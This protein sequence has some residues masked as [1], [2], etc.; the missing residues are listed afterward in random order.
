M[1]ILR[2]TLPLSISALLATVAVAP[3]AT[4]LSTADDAGDSTVVVNEVESNGDSD[5]DWV[6]L[7]NTDPNHSTDVSGWS[8]VDNDSEHEP[9]VLPEGTEIESEGHLIVPTEPDFGLG[10]EDSVT[11]SDSDGAKVDETEWSGHAATTWGRVPDM[12]GD[13]AETGKPTKGLANAASDGSGNGDNNDGASAEFPHDPLEITDIEL[14]G[15]YV[16]DFAGE[17]MSGVDFAPDGTAYVVNNDAGTLYVLSPQGDNS[18][19]I[20]ARRTLHYQDGSGEP[21]T[22][23]VTVGQDGALYVATERDNSEGEDDTSR[24]SVLRYVL[25][26][27]ENKEH[28]DSDL[29]ATDEWNLSELA[30]E[31]GDISANGGLETIS[32]ISDAADPALFAVGVEDTGEVLF[33]SLSGDDARLVQRYESPFEGVMASDYDAD[34]GELMIMCDEA[35]DGASQVLGSGTPGDADFAPVAP[36]D[37]ADAAVNSRPSGMEN[38]ANEGYARFLDEDGTER[39]LWAD[40]GVTDGVSLRGAVSNDSDDKDDSDGDNASGSIPTGSTR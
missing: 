18:Y 26:D 27:E 38:F 1:R 20:D 15:D 37:T 33:V 34:A 19:H 7:A 25:N 35:C 16:E 21:D 12:T 10:S 23:G 40:D 14:T 31:S 32:S 13:F 2:H 24:P 8:I 4:P 11:L 9:I 30:G 22:E 17:D 3:L 28:T 5:G 29:S 39:Y 36:T 6:E